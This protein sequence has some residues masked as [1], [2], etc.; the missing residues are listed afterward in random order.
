MAGRF[1]LV[2]LLLSRAMAAP[3]AGRRRGSLG[4][5]WEEVKEMLALPPLVV[6]ERVAS[7]PTAQQPRNS[8]KAFLYIVSLVLIL[9]TIFI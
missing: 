2:S 4:L 3:V 1:F 9:V 5:P 6:K 7:P 8:A